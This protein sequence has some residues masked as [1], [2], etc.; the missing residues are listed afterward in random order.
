MQYTHIN[1][2]LQVLTWKFIKAMKS[3]PL[4]SRRASMREVAKE[5][6]TIGR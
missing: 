2:V 4:M 5:W 6:L 3:L 1:A